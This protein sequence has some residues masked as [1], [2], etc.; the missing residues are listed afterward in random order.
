MTLANDSVIVTPGTGATI[1][2]HLAGGKEHQVVMLADAAGHLLDTLDTWYAY[3]GA[4][5]FVQNKHFLSLF[6]GAGSGKILKIRKCFV[7]NRQTAA[8]T[9][10]VF[11]FDF[12]R[13]TAQSGGTA[14]TPVAADTANAALPAQ[15]LIATNPTITNGGLLFS[16][17]F[18]NEEQA[19]LLT[20]PVPVLTASV[21]WLP[22]GRAIQELTLR[23][24]EG[25]TVQMIT[26]TTV[27]SYAVLVVFTVE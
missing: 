5:A 18:S 16:Q 6:N 17:L 1:A 7:T 11:Q 9:G 25:F 8:V 23:T 3:S 22:E 27:G 10:V 13:T 4:V 15:V 12:R 14:I 24:G 26:A 21:N 2:T 20:T 19:A